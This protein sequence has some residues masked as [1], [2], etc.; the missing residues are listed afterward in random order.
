MSGSE[1]FIRYG[2]SYVLDFLCHFLAFPSVLVIRPCR[3]LLTEYL[4]VY[5]LYLFQFTLIEV[6]TSKVVNYIKIRYIIRI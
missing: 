1:R 3:F 4:L 5:L 6:E 2:D